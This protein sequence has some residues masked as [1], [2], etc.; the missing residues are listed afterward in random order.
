MMRESLSRAFGIIGRVRKIDVVLS[1][2]ES[3]ETGATVAMRIMA[4]L[5][6]EPTQSGRRHVDIQLGSDCE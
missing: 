5:G 4:S 1:D 2:A 6:I 3:I